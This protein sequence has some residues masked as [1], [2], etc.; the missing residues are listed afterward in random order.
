MPNGKCH[1]DVVVDND[2]G[3]PILIL[4]TKWKTLLPLQVREH[5]KETSKWPKCRL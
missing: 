2:A 1:P 3:N 4:D 5:R